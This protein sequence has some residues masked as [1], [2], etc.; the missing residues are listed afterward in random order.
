MLVD[1]AVNWHILADGSGHW[2]VDLGSHT[3]YEVWTPPPMW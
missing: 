3:K 1:V 2:I